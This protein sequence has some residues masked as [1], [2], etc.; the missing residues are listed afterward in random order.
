MIKTKNPEQL[1]RILQKRGEKFMIQKTTLTTKIFW[2]DEKIFFVNSDTNLNNYELN[3]IRAV[4]T[5]V[6]KNLNLPYP[7]I[8]PMY[9]DLKP[10]KEGQEYKD[11]FELDLSAAF[12]ESAKE[13][14]IISPEIYA[15]GLHE[16][17]S[18]KARLLSLGNLAKTIIESN[19]NGQEYSP[20]RI[21]TSKLTEGCFFGCA[22]RTSEIMLICKMIL[23]ADYLFFWCDA[24]FFRPGIN[25][26]QKLAD[27]LNSIGY[28]FKLKKIS[29]MKHTEKK[30]YVYEGEEK[31][32]F[33]FKK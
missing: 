3:L 7:Y 19:F 32:V 31:R 1:I 15:K 12:W 25:N 5:H 20:A 28:P 11:L 23:G 13:L 6:E 4:K 16:K 14:N 10:M 21:I 18:K 26:V 27:F 33:N 24:I 8:K 29:F 22:Q 9:I 2:N 30:V 17:I